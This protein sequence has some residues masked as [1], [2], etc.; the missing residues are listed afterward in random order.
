MW[1]GRFNSPGTFAVYTY[2]SLSL[3]LLEI[4]VQTNDRTNLKKK[5]LLRANIPENVIDK[6][7][8][9]VLPGRW[10]QI[11]AAKESQSYGDEWLLQGKNPVLRIPSV[12]VPLEY[13]YLI[14]PAHKLFS[15]IDILKAE[16][17][18]V[19]PRFF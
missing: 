19:D 9:N 1:G 5:V 11:P 14:N 7:S 18:P 10:N 15:S 13:N 4:I 16:L 12:V 2:E 17:L 8:I 6:P 3:A